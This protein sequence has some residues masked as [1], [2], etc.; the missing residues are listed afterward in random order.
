MAGARVFSPLALPVGRASFRLVTWHER[1]LREGLELKI[2]IIGAG[3]IG[4]T[5][6][7]FADIMSVP[8]LQDVEV[9]LTDIDETGL[10]NIA[11]LL[12]HTVAA[13]KL[14]T[15]ITATTDRRRAIEGARYVMSCVRVGGL[16]AY[17]DDI[18]IPL[19][20]GVDQCV[21]DTICTGGILYG[22][23]NIP[24]ILDFCRDINEVAEHER[25]VPQLRQPDGDEHLGGD[26]IRQGATRSASATACSTAAS[27]SPRCSAPSDRSELEFIC[28][29]INH[30][31]WYIDIRLPRAG[32]SAATS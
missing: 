12:R 17:A 11:E 13:S 15:R 4:F 25:A 8:E 26:R 9:A 2:A 23:R 10:A 27:R 30:Q 3:S 19:K 14:P 21:G 6:R 28:S 29:G 1:A 22:Q 18:R 31:T 32:R 7:L 20:Y 24:V 5:R 16:E